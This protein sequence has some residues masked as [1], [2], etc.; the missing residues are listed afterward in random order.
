[1]AVALPYLLYHLGLL[2]HAAAEGDEHIRIFSFQTAQIAQTAVNLQIGVFSYGTRIIK[3][4]IGIFIRSLD[5]AGFL[6]DA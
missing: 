1:M 3:H 4:K 2:H 6:Q 5:K